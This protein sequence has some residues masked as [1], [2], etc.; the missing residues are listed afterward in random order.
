MLSKEEIN[1]IDINSLKKVHLIGIVSGFNSF[2]ANYLLE[3]GIKVTASEIN[4]DSDEAREWIERGVL[5]KGGHDAKYITNDIDLVIYPNGP[6]PGNPECERATELGV[7]AITIAQLTGIIS[8]YYKVIAIAG[9]HGKTTTSALI[10]WML[11]N[12][13]GMPNFIIGDHILGIN[14]S[15]NYTKESEYL[16]IE[17][18]EYKRQF[19]YRAPTPYV[20]VVTNIDID[21]TDYYTSQSDYNSAFEEFL[22]NTQ[23]SIVIDIEGKNDLEVINKVKENK[24]INILNISD[25]RDEYLDIEVP[26]IF[27]KHNKENMLRACGVAKVLNIK[28]DFSN[29][30]GVSSRFEYLGNTKYGMRVFLDYAHNPQ[31]VKSCLD[32]AKEEF[33]DEKILFVWQPHSHERTYSFKKEFG[34][35]ISSADIVY[36]PNIFSPTRETEEERSMISSQE[37]VKYLSDMNPNIDI[38]YINGIQNISKEI[39]D[40]KFN[41]SYICILA[42]AGDLKNIIPDLNLIKDCNGI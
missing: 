10:V 2:C 5:Y 8:R 9:T 15:W 39:L 3:K 7:R 34:E 16:V 19:L 17:A 18:C 13:L 12:T 35:S 14:K 20:S 22:S 42:S 30:P 28:A 26:N 29:F 36:I 40:E 37:F 25:I 38:Q 4:Q 21:H 32:G 23:H 33:T 31:K 41:S 24:D 6:I 1:K 11:K 27:G